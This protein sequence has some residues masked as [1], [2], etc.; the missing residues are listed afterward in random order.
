MNKTHDS[1]KPGC[2]CHEC[3]RIWDR[4]DR[5][6]HALRVLLDLGE[7]DLLVVFIYAEFLRAGKPEFLPDRV[8][9]RLRLFQHHAPEMLEQIV[10]DILD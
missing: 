4:R 9:W 7:I 2:T 1:S 6:A 5:A 10:A 3:L 8:Q